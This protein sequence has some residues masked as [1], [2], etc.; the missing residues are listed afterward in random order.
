MPPAFNLSQDQTLQFNLCFVP[1]LAGSEEP[2]LTQNT[3]R[4]VLANLPIFFCEHLINL[5]YSD[6]CRSIYRRTPSSTHTY[7]LLIFKELYLP[8][9][10]LP[11]HCFRIV[12]FVNSKEA[13]LC[14]TFDVPSS[15][16]NL[17]LQTFTFF[18][19]FSQ[20]SAKTAIMRH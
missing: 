6:T 14:S 15:T 10:L 20:N 17:L 3:D 13:R 8:G 5:K 11:E 4:N 7:R 19:V 18:P 9:V 1:F 2:S 12:L 16:P